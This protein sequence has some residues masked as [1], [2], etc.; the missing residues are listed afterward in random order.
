MCC[1]IVVCKLLITCYTI[2][3]FIILLVCSYMSAPITGISFLITFSANDEFM[4]PH[5]IGQFNLC[6]EGIKFLPSMDPNVTLQVARLEN[7]LSHSLQ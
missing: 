1:V 3:C 4:L 5:M 2:K 7:V 6:L